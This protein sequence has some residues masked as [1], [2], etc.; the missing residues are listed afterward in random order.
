MVIVDAGGGGDFVWTGGSIIHLP[1]DTGADKYI[2]KGINNPATSNQ[3]GQ[4]TFH[5]TRME[6]RSQYS[7]LV[8]W[9][10]SSAPAQSRTVYIKFDNV[11][12]T[13]SVQ[14]TGSL[15]PNF[16]RIGTAKTVLFENCMFPTD[17]AGMN[18]I[19]EFVVDSD[20]AY[21]LAPHPGL[22]L[23]N[24]CTAR[25]ALVDDCRIA[26][27]YGRIIAKGMVSASTP[28]NNNTGRRALDFDL[29]FDRAMGNACEGLPKV[30]NMLRN[31]WPLGAGGNETSFILPRGAIIRRITI[32]KPASSGSPTVTQWRIGLDNKSAFYAETPSAASQDQHSVD[33]FL[34]EPIPASNLTLRFWSTAGTLAQ[35]GGYALV[36]YI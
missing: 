10:V 25:S 15:R 35:T 12:L 18:D 29:G 7:K 26:N 30:L 28:A 34:N 21:T 20:P 5:N 3:N 19:Y 31:N 4:F 16:V 24:N 13:P 11:N 9:L 8:D 23:F 2:L 17:I 14:G 22:I 36:E 32:F 33:V 27:T 6:M 1:L